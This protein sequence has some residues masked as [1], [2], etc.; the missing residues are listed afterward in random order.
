M[1]NFSLHKNRGN[2][3]LFICSR[4]TYKL[5]SKS[6]IIKLC[7]EVTTADGTRLSLV[8]YLARFDQPADRVPQH[9]PENS[10]HHHHQ[11]PN[12]AGNISFIQS[13]NTMGWKLFEF[14]PSNLLSSAK[15][16]IVRAIKI[17]TQNA[18]TREGV[19]VLETLWESPTRGQPAEVDYRNISRSLGGKSSE[20]E[21]VIEF[22][23]QVINYSGLTHF[24]SLIYRTGETGR[25]SMVNCSQISRI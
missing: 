15:I 10:S 11:H 8:K 17:R 6:D 23:I 24:S 25:F 13:A 4:E 2:Y 22:I 19:K 5:D 14:W 9:Y 18:A 20:G 3:L 16:K 12:I 7:V 21:E 1:L